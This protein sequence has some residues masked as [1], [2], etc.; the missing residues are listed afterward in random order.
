MDKYK[1]LTVKEYFNR[2][3]FINGIRRA[4]FLKNKFHLIH[5]EELIKNIYFRKMYNKLNSFYRKH[6]N[7]IPK[8]IIY[9]SDVESPIWVLW[10]QG[11]DNAPLIV[12]KCVQSIK[13]HCCN[14]PVIV[15][16]E[17]N[18]SNYIIM[19]DMKNKN[20]S[21]ALYSDLLRFTLLEHYGGIWI[22]AT[23]L[24]T[25]DIPQFIFDSDYF[26]FFDDTCM[27]K[28]YA[29]MCNWF[30]S[31]KKNNVIAYETRNLLYAYVNRYK[32]IPEYLICYIFSTLSKDNNSDFY[33][34]NLCSNNTRLLF[35]SLD[36]KFNYNIWN[37]I[38]NASFL[39]KVTYKITNDILEDSENIYNFL[40]GDMSDV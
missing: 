27:I 14:K 40:I 7:D 11:L 28:N 17:E 37:N 29:L 13:K 9:N 4:F 6:K 36:S 20:I 1:K 22:D 23:V 26:C 16:S 32:N 8:G 19:P 18:V 5:D 38:L 34:S 33:I 3:G 2:Y 39:H 21:P 25:S 15:L 12:K 31:C 10:K 35:K 30:I 24:L